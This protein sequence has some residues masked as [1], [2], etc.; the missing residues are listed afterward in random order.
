MG[1]MSFLF[2][3]VCSYYFQDVKCWTFNDLNGQRSRYS[4]SLRA[5]RS[6]HRIPVGVRFS[7]P[8]QQSPGAHS[9]SSTMGTVSLPRG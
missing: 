3:Y 6:G 8:V 7:A 2:S 4:D 9:A 1:A 5:G